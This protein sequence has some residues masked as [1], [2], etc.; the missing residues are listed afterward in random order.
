MSFPSKLTVTSTFGV[1]P[2]LGGGQLRLFHLCRHLASRC[3]VELISLVADGEDPSRR[4]LARGLTEVRVPKS[5][6]HAAAEA[7]LQ[8]EA[9]V[10]V[11][12]VT[13]PEL[14]RETPAFG[15]AV[16][17]SA[18]GDG[19]FLVSHPYTLPVVESVAGRS[20]I[21]F[22]AQDVAVDLKASMLPSNDTGQRLLTGT[23][24]VEGRCCD[25]A[26]FVWPTCKE[27]ASRLQAL[28]GESDGKFV[29][30]PNG[31][32]VAAIHFTKPSE[33]RAL[34]QRLGMEGTTAL[35]IGSW[36]EPN[37]RAVRYLLELGR[38][39]SEV[40][41]AIVGSACLPFRGAQIPDN[42]KL[43]GVVEHG[44]KD[45]MLSVADV[46]LNPM[47][48]GS[49]TNIKMLDYLAAGVPAVSTEV[50][51]RGLGLEPDR[52]VRRASLEAFGTVIRDA[53]REPLDAADVRAER[54]RRVVEERFD[55]AV[56][57]QRLL[58]AVGGVPDD[59]EAT[60]RPPEPSYSGS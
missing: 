25:R 47:S 45:A 8:R 42:V 33:R 56:I 51:L 37:L 59:P 14:H 16:M 38:Q 34:R 17:R 55:W 21:W 48:E 6:R 43:L 30:V 58:A 50:G 49:G 60:P 1:F 36:H 23:R 32:D 12:D 11:T 27:D 44:L 35:F 20:R 29:V 28:Y 15:E 9:G 46:A 2:P 3:P 4:E 18:S 41:F 7:E 19:A 5:P 10:P 40:E 31:I 13:F 57:G 54:A 24:E 22:D 52:D 53:L 39:I 26:E